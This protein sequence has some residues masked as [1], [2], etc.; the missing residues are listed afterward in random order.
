MKWEADD[1]T[2][3][4]RVDVLVEASLLQRGSG[5]VLWSANG[6]DGPV[7]TRGATSLGEAYQRAAEA[8][9]DWLVGRWRAAR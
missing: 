2:K 8:V 4:E 5:K 9:A 6:P 3:P 1:V 7:V